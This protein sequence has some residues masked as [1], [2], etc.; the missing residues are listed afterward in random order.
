[1]TPQDIY[2][3]LQNHVQAGARLRL[4]SRTVTP[5]DVLFACPG[6]SGDGR[7]H[8]DAAIAAGAAAPVVLAP[9][10]EQLARDSVDVPV[11]EVGGLVSLLGAVAYLRYGRPSEQ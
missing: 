6:I 7:S 4:D 11:L 2:D 9:R 8:A 1:M 3:W 10:L 5:G